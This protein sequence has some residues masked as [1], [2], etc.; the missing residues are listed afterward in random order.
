MTATLTAPT[1]TL[2][3]EHAIFTSIRTPMGEG[4]RVV[5]AS[6]GI[7]PD[8]KQEI[9]QRSPSHDSLCDPGESAEGLAVWRLRSG[10]IC[11]AH[12]RHAGAEH[13]ARGG[14]R[15]YTLIAILEPAAYCAL[16]CDPALVAQ[17]MLA[18]AGREPL[19]KPPPKLERLDLG[20]PPEL[21][22]G[23][24]AAA[25]E[26]IAALMRLAGSVLG[27][28]RFVAHLPTASA[29]TLAT[30]FAA[31]PLCARAAT[32]AT[33]GLKFA[34]SRPVQLALLPRVSPEAARLIRG[35]NMTL[36]DFPASSG[37]VL[38][39]PA[40]A[41]ASRT[42][43][44]SADMTGRA[45]E[46]A[47]CTPAQD[48]VSRWLG[49][50]ERQWR[51]GRSE[52]VARVSVQIDAEATPERLGRIVTMLDDLER[53]RLNGAV[54]TP[55]VLQRMGGV[56][57]TVTQD[58]LE[59]STSPRSRAAPASFDRSELAQRYAGP[60]PA[61]QPEAQLHAAIHGAIAACVDPGTC[62][63]SSKP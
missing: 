35:Q 3:A 56:G 42:P 4:Y 27:G 9:T 48:P 36:L 33:V 53:L 14:M 50:V 10:R 12:S 40:A 7:A 44:R 1:T 45:V 62:I 2:T 24:R 37:S 41:A 54:T 32:S 28:E 16:A 5:A 60:P 46:T 26:N 52:E 29:N 31:L 17:R 6:G 8:E 55:G 11:V 57:A 51:A 39:G 59:L 22:A 30:L 15:V 21:V 61:S 47:G 20:A 34:T 19:L 18:A 23:G 43:A 49:W 58:S 13:T 63:P 38:P 25:P